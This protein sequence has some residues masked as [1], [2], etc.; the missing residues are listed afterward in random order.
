MP[1]QSPSPGEPRGCADRYLP[2]SRCSCPRVLKSGQ[3][4]SALVTT[5]NHTACLWHCRFFCRQYRFFF[6]LLYHSQNLCTTYSNT[7]RVK[8]CLPLA[9]CTHRTIYYQYLS[10]KMSNGNNRETTRQESIPSLLFCTG[11][12]HYKSVNAELTTKG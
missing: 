5:P 11:I 4:H 12:C 2:A 9:Q 6:S 10:D 3:A 7:L 1:P 8:D